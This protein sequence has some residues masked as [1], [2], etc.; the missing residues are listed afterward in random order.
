M[1]TKTYFYLAV[2]VCLG[3]WTIDILAWNVPPL[4]PIIVPLIYADTAGFLLLLA[5]YVIKM[6]RDAR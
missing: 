4:I 5:V 1:R 6:M 2:Y 3:C